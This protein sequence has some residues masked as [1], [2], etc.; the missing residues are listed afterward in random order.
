MI[1][2]LA[3]MVG[4]HGAC[5]WRMLAARTSLLVWPMISAGDAKHAKFLTARA[6]GP[7]GGLW[8]LVAALGLAV[9]RLFP[10]DKGHCI[11][12]V[13]GEVVRLLHADQSNLGTAPER[14]KGGALYPMPKVTS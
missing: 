11:V 1:G 12:L 13:G 14:F 2:E 5:V 8:H 4:E 3:C 7:K 10:L 9:R 6:D